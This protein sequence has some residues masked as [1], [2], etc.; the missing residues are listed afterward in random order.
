MLSEIASTL[1]RPCFYSELSHP[2]VEGLEKGYI[3][4]LLIHFDCHFPYLSDKRELER[5]RI[6]LEW[7]AIVQIVK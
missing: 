1:L 3:H 7:K 6:G 4:S 5:S 2:T